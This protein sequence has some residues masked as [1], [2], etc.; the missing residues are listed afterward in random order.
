MSKSWCNLAYD[1]VNFK[2]STKA[3]FFINFSLLSLQPK[4]TD[5]EKALRLPSGSLAE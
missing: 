4:V 2:S 3:T 1:A 5:G